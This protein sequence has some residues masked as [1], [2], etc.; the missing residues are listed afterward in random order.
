[1]GFHRRLTSST[2]FRPH[3]GFLVVYLVRRSFPP[4]PS[5]PSNLSFALDTPFTHVPLFHP[6]FEPCRTV[7]KVVLL[8]WKP[9]LCRCYC[10]P[11]LFTLLVSLPPHWAHYPLPLRFFS[12]SNRSWSGWIVVR[13][14]IGAGFIGLARFSN[15]F[16]GWS[17]KLRGSLDLTAGKFV[18]PDAL[19]TFSRVSLAS[20]SSLVFH[21]RAAVF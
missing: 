21:V 2:T 4:F 14:D 17:T 6:L 8:N 20:T 12:R 3:R 15:F 11:L 16:R 18:C 9:Q 1:M 10:H 13:V 19:I 5:L 7:Y